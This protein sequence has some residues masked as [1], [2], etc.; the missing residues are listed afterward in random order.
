MYIPPRDSTSTHYKT[1]DKEIQHSIQYRPHSVLT[2]DMNAHST[3]WHSYTEHYIGQ[4]IADIS[5]SGHITLNTNPPTRVLNTTLQ[6]TSSPEITTVSNTQYNR[7]AWTTQHALSSDHL[8]I[9]TTI[10]IRHDYILQQNRQTFT[11]YKKADWTQSTE[12]TESA[13]AQTTIPTNIHT[14]NIICTNILLMADKHNIPN[15]KMHI[16]CRLL[17]GHIVCKITQQNN[18]RIANTCDP[19]LK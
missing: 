12:D 10:N 19:A 11:N 7:T 5:N 18:I 6:Q 3:L 8:P 9:I 14:A 15:G 4:L 16:N 2:E 17:P 1:A 13:F